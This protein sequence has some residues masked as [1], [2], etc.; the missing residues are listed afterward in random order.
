MIALPIVDKDRRP[1]TTAIRDLGWYDYF[2]VSFSGGKDSIA[3]ALSLRK[4][5]VP[6]NRIVYSDPT[7]RAPAHVLLRNRKGASGLWPYGISGDLPIVLLRI[8]HPDDQDIVRQLLRAHEYWRMKGLAVDLVILWATIIW[9]VV[10]IWRHFR[11][12]ALAQDS[13]FV[14]VSIATVIQLS[15]TAMNWDRP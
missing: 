9:S 15:I 2:L 4:R 7:L 3:L 13:Y 5:G 10:A 14:W 6:A 11:W 1:N 8:D 12:V